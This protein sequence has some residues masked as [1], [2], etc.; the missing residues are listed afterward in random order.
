MK[1]VLLPRYGTEEVLQFGEVPTPQPEPHE[2]LVR[3]HA[4]SLNDWDWAVVQ[5]KP[6]AARLLHGLLR[7]RVRI[8]GCDM[9]GR[10]EA[11]GS[12]VT[13]LQPGDE[14]YGDLCES[15]FGT[16]AEYVCA[17][18]REVGRK[19]AGMSFEQAAAIPQAGM[20]AVQGMVDVGGLRAGQSILLNGAG[21]GVGTFAL[22]LAKLHD[23]D[24]TVVDKAGKLD[25]LRALGADH[26]V[27]Y[28]REDFTRS[29]RRYDLILDVKTD[30]PLRAYA[31]ALNPGGVYATVGGDTG[32][33]LRVAWL[34]SR[35]GGGQGRRLRLVALKPN[36]DL[37]YVNELFEAGRLK[38][39]L[40]RSY[41]LDEV[42][43]AFRHLATGDH[44]GKIVLSMN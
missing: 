21:G 39:V 41:R 31:G 30:R 16:F 12:Q 26:V 4:A 6:F 33:L 32:R 27:D 13:T 17:P 22:Q 10:V 29:G 3:V 37:A 14:V 1:A 15:G 11:V 9:A 42:R 44:R 8:P 5:G 24:V 20:L 34:G 25:M 7:P 2:V 35:L 36:K 40:D 43:E 23:V 18:A 19:P 38:P 28:T